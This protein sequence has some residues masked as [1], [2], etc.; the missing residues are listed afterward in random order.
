[1]TL[2]EKPGLSLHHSLGAKFRKYVGHSAHVTNVRFTCDHHH[3]ISVGG[4]DHAIFQWK[5]LPGGEEREEEGEQLVGGTGG[6]V[7]VPHLMNV[8]LLIFLYS[9]LHFLL[10]L[11]PS[12]PPPPPLLPSSPPPLLP[13]SP[14]PLL[15]SS[16][17]P[18]PSSPPP[19]LPL[20]FS[21][22][23]SSLISC[24]D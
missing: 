23:S 13:S 20:C 12:P 7:Y 8:I 2:S 16:P 3:V 18:L 22:L 10:P 14:P 5:F 19:L 11:L 6:C 21:L 15:P 4:A 24:G 9:L 17:P 1:M